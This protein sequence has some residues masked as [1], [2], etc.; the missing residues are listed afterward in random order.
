M[1][2][3]DIAASREATERPQHEGREDGD[4]TKKAILVGAAGRWAKCDRS[5]PRD[6]RDP[7][8]P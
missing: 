2:I 3:A 4:D 8:F 7:R 1:E 6:P 5:N